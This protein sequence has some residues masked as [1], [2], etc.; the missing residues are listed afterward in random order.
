MDTTK[1][2]FIKMHGCGNDYIYFNGMDV[3][4]PDVLAVKLSDRNKS[5]GGDGVVLI[6]PS[7]IADAKMQMYNADGSEGLMCGN[8]IR[9]VGKYLFDNGMV[10]T[11]QMTI[12]TASGVKQLEL[13]RGSCGNITA[14]RVDMGPAL[15]SPV[16]IPVNLSGSMIVDRT[17]S[18]AGNH[19]EVTCVS[20]G[21]PHAI[22]FHDDID[23]YDLHKT[24]AA[25]EASGVFPEGV[26][27]GVVQMAGRN[28]M[29][30]RVW[31]R[32]TGETMASGTGACAAAVAA[33]LMGFCDKDT[34]IKVEV[35]GG[36]LTVNYTD[37]AV[38]M[39]GDCVTIYEGVVNL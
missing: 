36:V 27:V 10:K 39:T 12:E 15:L 17:I 13:L 32:G 30:M 2:K 28:N 11:M 18:I 26:N 4:N 31:E 20:M 33:V 5:I 1:T 14:A 35:E 23:H 29:R 19:Y 16:Q 37:A 7:E 38:Y 3:K 8:S 25:F 6:L 24:G 34:D 22:I 9:C 21:N